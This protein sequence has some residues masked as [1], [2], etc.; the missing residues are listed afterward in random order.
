[1][2]RGS[3]GGA[4]TTKP[5]GWLGFL[6]PYF[7]LVLSHHIHIAFELFRFIYGFVFRALI[8]KL[9]LGIEPIRIGFSGGLHGHLIGLLFA[10]KPPHSEILDISGPPDLCMMANNLSLLW[11][12]HDGLVRGESQ[13]FKERGVFLR[14]HDDQIS[15]CFQL[16]FFTQRRTRGNALGHTSGLQ[17]AR[18]G[19]RPPSF[20]GRLSVRSSPKNVHASSKSSLVGSE[21]AYPPYPQE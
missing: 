6:K 2:A 1:M 21:L 9:C 12:K 4:S 10:Q 3:I 17:A 5:I 16:G 14:V 20:S 15:S 18:E 11:C 19:P 7:I 8:L 13:I